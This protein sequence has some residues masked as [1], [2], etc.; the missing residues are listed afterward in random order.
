MTMDLSS[1]HHPRY[2][3]IL[4][5]LKLRPHPAIMSSS[6]RSCFSPQELM[7]LQSELR[8]S[9]A[10]SSTGVV[11][12]AGIASV[13]SLF[14]FPAAINLWQTV[15]GAIS[16]HKVR[17][18]MKKRIKQFPELKAIFD[19]AKSWGPFLQDI[20]IGIFF[21]LAFTAGGCGLIGS[22]SIAQAGVE[23]FCQSHLTASLDHVNHAFNNLKTAHPHMS[24]LDQLLHD[25]NAGFAEN[26]TNRLNRLLLPD[27]S[28]PL[29]ME[30]S[31]HE[32]SQLY[33]DDGVPAARIALEAG[34]MAAANEFMQP[35]VMTA[36]HAVE[37]AAKAS[38]RHRCRKFFKGH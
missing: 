23:K 22:R 5:A 8:R 7:E 32:L 11:I 28:H 16:L 6:L 31:H 10:S 9:I 27:A 34:P 21:K 19:K 18:E 30:A 35:V 36:E 13:C 25:A 1:K 4:A 3:R 29:A 2:R 17:K 26:T 12:N 24:Q 20:T 33:H 14:A 38:F 37:K 15:V